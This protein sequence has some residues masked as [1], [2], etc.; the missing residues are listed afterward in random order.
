MNYLVIGGSSGIGKEYILNLVSPE[1]VII[2]GKRPELDFEIV[3]S[4]RYVSIDL[5]DPKAISEFVTNNEISFDRILFSAGYLENNPLQVFDSSKWINQVAVNLTSIGVLLGTLYRKRKINKDAN[6]VIISSIN[7]TVRGS[8]GCIGY[9]SAKAGIEG[10]VRVFANEAGKK[11]IKINS[12]SPGMVKT[13]LMDGLNHI[14]NEQLE[15]DM[16]RYPLG[17][18]Y[19][20]TSDINKLI[21]YFL[22]KNTYITGQNIII[23][24]GHTIAG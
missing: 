6:I 10:F 5:A 21:D 8:K 14:S 23:D 24:G 9:A 4:H 11:L 13:P 1:N 19:A 18:R 3:H 16:K 20:E 22:E 2:L 15:L 17:G 7:G 12:I